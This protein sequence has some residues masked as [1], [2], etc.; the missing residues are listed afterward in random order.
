MTRKFEIIVT[1]GTWTDPAT[2]KKVKRTLP[3]GAIYESTGG[4]LVLRIDA[5]PVSPDWSGWAQL[6]PCTRET[7]TSRRVDG[8]EPDEYSE[9]PEEENPAP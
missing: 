1:V 8:P 4:K 5:I 2:G 3:V 7:P 6:K 9:T